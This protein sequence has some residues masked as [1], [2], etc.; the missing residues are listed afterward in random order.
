M[1]W[2]LEVNMV[3]GSIFF[4]AL[5]SRKSGLTLFMQTGAET[6]VT[7][8]E[9]VEP[10]HAVLCKAIPGGWVGDESTEPCCALQ[11]FRI[12]SVIR[13]MCHTSVIVV[14]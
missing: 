6:S 3:N 10:D 4:T 14:K 11:P 1:D 7:G 2:T 9:A 12:P 5:T 13:P 8:S